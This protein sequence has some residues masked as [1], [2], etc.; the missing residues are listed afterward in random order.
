MYWRQ[1][2]PLFGGLK[3]NRTSN[4]K[5]YI[6]YRKNGMY[7]RES[8]ADMKKDIKSIF[9]SGQSTLNINEVQKKI[10]DNFITY[11][12]AE[13]F[14]QVELLKQFNVTNDDIADVI[15]SAVFDDSSLT[16][17]Q[18]NHAKGIFSQIKCSNTK[19]KEIDKFINDA[20]K[21]IASQSTSSISEKSTTI[22]PPTPIFNATCKKS[23]ESSVDIFREENGL[24]IKV[25]AGKC[26]VENTQVI[27]TANVTKSFDIK[28]IAEIYKNS[29]K[30]FVYVKTRKQPFILFSN[31]IDDLYDAIA[32]FFHK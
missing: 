15:S 20:L 24:Y 8:V 16:I 11:N 28:D 3:Y 29:G 12:D 17:D 23:F 4:G 30:L 26:K 25:S 5:D 6:S 19:K 9:H 14:N 18:I 32:N 1:S 21:Q 7:I 31:N 10:K 2:I 27:I 22:P 13:I